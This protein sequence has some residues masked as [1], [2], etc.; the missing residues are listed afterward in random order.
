MRAP[1]VVAAQEA[2]ELHC[3]RHEPCRNV[4]HQRDLCDEGR[5]LH[6]AVVRAA[7]VAYEARP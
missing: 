2:L 3:Q 7:R 5:G 6:D 4:A 1:A